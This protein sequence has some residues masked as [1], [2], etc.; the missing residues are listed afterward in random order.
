MYTPRFQ[1]VIHSV[2]LHI[3]LGFAQDISQADIFNNCVNSNSCSH[4]Y[5]Q[6]YQSLSQSEN[7][8]NISHALYPGRSKPSSVHV[9]VNV[10]GPNKTT[11][12]AYTWS[13]SCIYAAL[14]GA[15]LQVLSLG[16]ILVSPRTQELDIQIPPFC[17]NVSENKEERKQKTN[18]MLTKALA[19]VS[20]YW[21]TFL[22][23]WVT[24]MYSLLMSQ[25]L[26]CI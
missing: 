3:M 11:P 5:E 23:F 9:F 6:V 10:Y 18:G 24:L 20:Y 1:E 7:N 17:C 25:F 2:F 14:P 12:A 26:Q 21:S 13:M 22:A 19:E 8:F 15:V 4:T 16:S